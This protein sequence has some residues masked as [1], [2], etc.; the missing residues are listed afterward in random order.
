MTP[1]DWFTSHYADMAHVVRELDL[2]AYCRHDTMIQRVSAVPGLKTSTG[3]CHLFFFLIIFIIA[4][5]TLFLLF[6]IALNDPVSS[7]LLSVYILQFPTCSL[8]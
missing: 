5:S 4:T 7:F 1:P 3:K 6:S 8:K 2:S